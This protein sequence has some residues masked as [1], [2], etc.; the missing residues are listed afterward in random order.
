MKIVRIDTYLINFPS[1]NN[2]YSPGIFIRIA[3]KYQEKICEGWGEISWG[4]PSRTGLTPNIVFDDLEKRISLTLL[5]REITEPNQLLDYS[6]LAVKQRLGM[7]PVISGVE[8]ALIDLWGKIH[9]KPVLSLFREN[10][11]NTRGKLTASNMC[12]VVGFRDSEKEY[13]ELINFLQEQNEFPDYIL[14]PFSEYE[15]RNYEM[16]KKYFQKRNIK[17]KITIDYR[18]EFLK[19]IKLLANSNLIDSAVLN[20][21]RGG[22][23]AIINS[24]LESNSFDSKN[25]VFD[26][27]DNKGPAL[28]Y[29][30]A[31]INA[32]SEEIEQGFEWFARKPEKYENTINQIIAT[33]TTKLQTGNINFELPGLGICLDFDF[34][35]K[36]IEKAS[37]IYRKEF[38]IIIRKLR[39]FR[40]KPDFKRVVEERIRGEL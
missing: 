10:T 29:G 7:E 13:N 35:E 21:S 11:G 24:L 15:F 6:N 25:L 38:E 4:K 18:P 14:N 27:S 36:Y 9:N 22:N 26:F 23:Y 34:I 19:I 12:S 40:G 32:F 16:L 1:G 3:G 30:L 5:N 37:I 31:L 39:Y 33:K 2:L 8:T 20:F 28:A 17:T